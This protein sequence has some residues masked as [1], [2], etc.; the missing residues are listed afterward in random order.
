MGPDL[1]AGRP[2]RTL[3]A[4]GLCAE[5][6]RVIGFVAR[7]LLS[8]IPFV[9]AATTLVF[10]LVEAAPGDPFDRLRE[11]GVSV[12]T[13]ARLHEAFGTT[14][15]FHVRYLDWLGGLLQG[16]LGTSWSYR[17]PAAG[18]VRDAALNTLVLAGPALVLQFALGLAAGVA[19]ARSRSGFADRVV[20][21]AAA[22]LY[23]VPSYCLAL[24]LA[25]LMAV[26]LGWLP[27]SQMHSIDSVDLPA[28]SRLL[29]TLR[30][31]ALPCL[32]LVLP[33]AGGIALYVR[34][35][36][37]DALGRGFVSAAR[38]RGLG[39]RQA[40]MRHALR[41]VLLPVAALLGVALPGLLGGSVAIEVLFAWPGLG[42][43]AYQAVLARDVP[44]IL[45]CTCLS[46][47]LVAAGGLLADLAA[48]ALDPRA[49][50]AQ[51]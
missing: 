18:L 28:L 8:T 39:S 26:R 42:R 13:A 46:S 1:R 37:R 27:A 14:R 17:Q 15:P 31:L 38:A 50:E 34:D 22:A 9:W 19:A 48:A 16:D 45:G 11:P 2:G 4:G 25:W 29:D 40:D 21:L 7:R 3:T 33:A 23:A 43:L 12:R 24:P 32:A 6:L 30:H 47:L 36:M 35:Q 44:L 51:T 49:R 5:Y 41:A 10:L 20:S